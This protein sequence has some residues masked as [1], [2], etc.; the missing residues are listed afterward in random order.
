M[1]NISLSDLTMAL[2]KADQAGN[3]DDARILADAISNHPEYIQMINVKS[4]PDK[5][6]DQEYSESPDQEQ[7]FLG[8]IGSGIKD[9]VTGEKRKTEST[10]KASALMDMPEISRGNLFATMASMFTG[11]QEFADIMKQIYPEMEIKQDEKGN[12]LF[13]SMDTGK[14]HTDKPGISKSNIPQLIANAATFFRAGK[15]PTL[16]GRMMT[17]G[18]TQAGIE[19]LQS[20]LGGQADISDVALAVASEPIGDVVA[21]VPGVAKKGLS[22]GVEFLKNLIPE[23]IAETQMTSGAEQFGTMAKEAVKSKFLRTNK[24][25]SLSNELPIDEGVFN[26]AERLGLTEYLQPDHLTTNQAYKSYSQAIKSLPGS[27]AKQLEIEGLQK[28]AEKGSEL[29][30]QFGGTEDY[31]TLSFDI[32]QNM[33]KTIDGLED[34]SNK[35]YNEL[36]D[37]IDPKTEVETNNILNFIENRADEL[38]GFE[39]ISAIEKN[40]YK[41]LKPKKIDDVINDIT[42]YA[43]IISKTAEETAR[44][45]QKTK[46]PTYA[47]LD[48]IRKDI[49]SAKYS[50]Q[51]PFKDAQ[52]GLLKKLESL[53]MDDQL[54]V[55]DDLN[56]SDLFNAA[57]KTVAIR[58]GIE[59][60]M[61]SIFGRE[62]EKSLIP[63]LTSAIKGLP[64]GNVDNF[65]NFI[66]RIPENNRQEVVASG[67][68]VAMGK[69][70]KNG[71][72]NFKNF[73]DYWKR[74]K[75][76]K[77]AYTALM[78]NLPPESS[79]LLNSYANISRAIN[80]TS[81]FIG[82]GRLNAIEKAMNGTDNLIGKIMKIPLASKALMGASY[83][84][85]P[86]ITGFISVINAITSTNRKGV[87]QLADDLISSNDFIM[88]VK[89]LPI[90]E[91]K[92]IKTIINSPSWIKYQNQAMKIDP[93]LKNPK[94]WLKSALRL[95]TTQ[96]E[97]N[98]NDR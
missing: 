23:Q 65:I 79:S 60:D 38:G 20:Q 1:A 10:E 95:D 82:T 3:I 44:S 70:A 72:M 35:L 85:A 93:E 45:E 86:N 37:S 53:L 84:V 63:P 57:R 2:Q 64:D 18:A 49:T 47:L 83:S 73:S 40:I 58:K 51:G 94:L 34:Q 9:A 17:S 24:I 48:S 61:S 31:S 13:K 12:F 26:D 28:I 52:T 39:N 46:L 56:V 27:K 36:R 55:A 19:G 66:K 74:L 33:K 76:N 54:I 87:L 5:L 81:R 16:R 96:R 6:P 8:R 78:S 29:I 32:K 21:A 68:S 88:A 7:G 59:D 50:R 14:W 98:Q 69:Q 15:Q 30:E 43:P 62:I 91:D 77:K 22:K 41:K 92:A 67:L 75:E 89:Q 71:N 4:E 97:D 42:G 90:D 80:E 25:R 11:G